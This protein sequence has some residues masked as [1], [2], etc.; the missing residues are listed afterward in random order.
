[1]F[2]PKA[3]TGSK[4]YGSIA[5][6]GDLFKDLEI[7]ES[8]RAALAEAGKHGLAR[9]TWSTYNTAEKALHMCR[10]EIGRAFM[11]P[12][13]EEDI[14][15]FIGWLISVRKVKAST[16]SG[17]LAGIRQAHVNQGFK[18]PTIR[19]PLVQLVLKGKSNM[20]SIAD[21]R[22]DDRLPI[23]IEKMKELKV[24]TRSWEAGLQDKLLMWAISTL[25][26]HGGFRI[27]EL[28]CK[29]ESTF[30]PDFDLLG[31]DI[32]TV[33]DSEQLNSILRVKLKCSK[34]NKTGKS[35]IVEIHETKGTLCPVKA[36]TRWGSRA[37][38]A[39]KLPLFRKQ[40]GVPVTGKCFNIWLKD[41][42]PP[43]VGGKHAA[44]SFRIGLASTMAAKGLST[45]E[46]KEAGR[47]SSN[48]YEQYIRLHHVKRASAATAI[49][50]LDRYS[51]HG[52]G[53]YKNNICNIS[54]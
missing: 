1:M 12:L 28:L 3:I 44:H 48:A 37:S 26:F 49:S 15:E 11:F 8:S 40:S 5:G 53:N 47:W 14:L 30:D 21:R 23:T 33:K 35:V 19:T 29:T 9:S 43:T 6:P 52:T 50:R 36:F 32:T 18:A 38:I 10:K 27:H 42:L 45:K 4:K 41:M 39:E 13:N 51:E 54:C 7:S 25:A 22:R 24:R 20:D 17:Y 31:E 46:I 2:S 16:I 34:E